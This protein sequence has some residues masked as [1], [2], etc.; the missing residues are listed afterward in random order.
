MCEFDLSLRSK[1]NTRGPRRHSSV[2]SGLDTLL[3]G[4]KWPAIAQHQKV[5]AL[6]LGC[7]VGADRVQHTLAELTGAGALATTEERAMEG[8]LAF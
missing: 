7:V 2:Q 6:A 3:R 1:S 8:A 4:G 5:S